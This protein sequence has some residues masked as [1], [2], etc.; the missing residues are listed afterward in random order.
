M[1]KTNLYRVP[2]NWRE[3]PLTPAIDVPAI[4]GFS[5]AKAYQLAE[6]GELD[7]RRTA[8]RTFVTTESLARLLDCAEPYNP[9]SNSGRTAPAV[10]ARRKATERAWEA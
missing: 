2:E 6:T 10:A 5:V 3:R 9:R 1:R 7:F 4:A 8:G